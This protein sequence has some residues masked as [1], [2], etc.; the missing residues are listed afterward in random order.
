M[1]P[2]PLFARPSPAA[3]PPVTVGTTARQ[4]KKRSPAPVPGGA[5]LTPPPVPTTSTQLQE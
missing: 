5:K 2:T 1:G 4:R 3:V